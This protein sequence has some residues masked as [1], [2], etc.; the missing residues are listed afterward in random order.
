MNAPLHT[1]A[2]KAGVGQGSLYRH[3]PDRI[4]LAVAVFENNVAQI[5]ALAANPESTLDDLLALITDKTIESIAFVEIVTP[6]GDDPRMGAIVQRVEDALT[7]T[8]LRAR[9]SGTVRQSV[10]SDEV[11]LAVSMVT[12][13]VA[14]TPVDKR[15]QT[16]DQ[17]WS[18]LHRALRP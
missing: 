5:E 12:A 9:R 1:V 17:A 13:L 8:L 16:A 7:T 6:A 11:M 14:K 3:F 4:S 2:K 15:R 10:R 18:L